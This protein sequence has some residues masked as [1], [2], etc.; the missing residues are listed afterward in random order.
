MQQDKN[1][2]AQ[3]VV[4]DN[5]LQLRAAVLKYLSYWKWFLV[6]IVF[7]VFLGFLYLKTR[8]NIYE[9]SVSVLLK[10]ENTASEETLLLQDLGMKAGKNNIENEIAIF[11]SPDLA[12]RVIISLELYT[13][14]T[15]DGTWGVADMEMYGN[16][17]LYVRWEDIDPET[18]PASVTFIFTPD[19]QGFRVHGMYQGQPFEA[20]IKK[21]PVYLKLSM[22]RF[23]VS[24]GSNP[25]PEFSRTPYEFSASI[26]NPASMART[27]A[28]ALLVT[29]SSKQSS[30]LT[31]SIQ[32]QNRQKGLDYL[33]QLIHFYNEDATND[34]NM[35][36]HNT[37]V[38]IDER[39]KEISVELGMVEKKV[40]DFRQ[41]KQVTDI[42][43]E[44]QLFLGQTGENE[45]KRVEVETQLNLIR[46]VEDFIR[47]ESN[48]NKLIPNLG[49]SDAGLVTVINS[50]NQLLLQKE[51]LE[52]SSSESN[53]ALIQMKGQVARMRQNIQASLTN[54][55]RASEIALQELNRQ[56]TVTNA[57][58]QNI[59][60]V[61]RQYKDILRQQEVKNNLFVFLLQKREET[62]LTQAAVAPKAKIVSK[63]YTSDQPVSPNRLVILMVFFLIGSVLPVGSIFIRDLFHTRIEGINDL[64]QLQDID[65][66]GDIPVLRPI[67]GSA[68]IV[69]ENDDSPVVELFR[70]LRNNLLFML[71]EPRKKVIMVTSTIPSE[72]KTLI[73]INL[74]RSL[75]LMEKSVLL[76]GG[77]IRNPKLSHDLG[78]ERVV[79]GFSSL[80]AGMDKDYKS[81][82]K[83]MYPNLHILQS[84]AVPPNPNELFS[85]LTLEQL[86]VRLRREYD[87]IVIDSAPVGVVSDSFMLNRISDLTLYIMR[88][89]LTQKDTVHFLNSIKRDGRLKNLAVV[90]NGSSLDGKYGNYKY[91]YKYSYRYGYSQHYGY[92][93]VKQKV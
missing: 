55:R 2:P 67:K 14:Y 1:Q 53:P 82:I 13:T 83:E 26:I 5:G 20:Q 30:V 85:R 71:N 76:I 6:S 62:A 43:V 18:I 78:I 28:S 15:K 3:R 70:T 86:F 79:H 48:S 63:P 21:L 58:I 29:P 91:G 66:I 42:A 41:A 4:P 57:R 89:K 56:N 40:E 88:E 47:R 87:Y 38:F 92:K 39:I 93:T 68:L 27:L 61:E 74:A 34:K 81:L 8:V 45:Q 32:S 35:V 84:G 17:P 73:S 46:F 37:A 80:L 90:L 31:L 23:Y 59:P 25:D 60:A 9:N 75:S 12:S 49:V 24:R 69:K 51:R 52:S 44:A 7:F 50:Y 36:A 77:D 22:G 16:A 64:E 19:G 72:G 54:V 11:K 33:K 65:V 10:D